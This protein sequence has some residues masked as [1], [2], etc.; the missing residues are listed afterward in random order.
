MESLVQTN[1]LLAVFTNLDWSISWKQRIEE[2]AAAFFYSIW[3]KQT[4][5][6]ALD[7]VNLNDSNF[8]FCGD[9]HC[10]KMDF[11]SFC[12]FKFFIFPWFFLIEL[13]TVYSEA[14]RPKHNFLAGIEVNWTS[15]F[16][17]YFVASEASTRAKRLSWIYPNISV[18]KSESELS[19][20][21]RTKLAQI[22]MMQRGGLHECTLPNE[23][24]HETFAEFRI[25]I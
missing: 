7:W 21:W 3:Q 20:H 12:F 14:E 9:H 19:P 17:K 23:G 15:L 5:L 2:K 11:K 8:V 22:K 25:S 24:H 13:S 18:S 10:L 4:E 6:W 16:F 1:F